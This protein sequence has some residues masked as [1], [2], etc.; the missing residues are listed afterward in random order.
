[1]PDETMTLTSPAF[2]DGAAIPRRHA[3]DGDDLSPPLAWAGAPPGTRSLA[4]IV[5]DPD[6]SASAFVHWVAWGIAPD[7]RG[8]GE[9]ERAPGEGRNG[10]GTV[11]YRGPCPP[12]GDGA[13]RYVFRLHA[14]D[15]EITLRAG[16]GADDLRK[17]IAGHVLARG[18]LV[19]RYERPVL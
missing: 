3:C 5:D 9:G 19:G 15:A 7:A 4:L 11:G 8:L 14:L 17:A 6:A 10:F 13:H 16:A 12:P 2:A 18:E 1:M